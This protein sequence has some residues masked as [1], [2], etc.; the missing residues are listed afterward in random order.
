MDFQKIFLRRFPAL[1]GPCLS[2]SCGRAVGG[3]WI[4]HCSDE[5][6][7]GGTLPGFLNSVWDRP[8]RRV[9]RLTRRR[10]PTFGPSEIPVTN[11][12]GSRLVTLSSDAA[13]NNNYRFDYCFDASRR[14]PEFSREAP[15]H[16]RP[17]PVAPGRTLPPA[18]S[19]QRRPS[20]RERQSF[21]VRR[22]TVF[23]TP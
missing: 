17:G 8:A 1:T 4:N 14:R 23:G 11:R 15:S 19:A 20:V 2:E 12:A 21:P 9:D 7:D 5:L 18:P 16:G 3:L 22:G 10:K 13:S 6:F